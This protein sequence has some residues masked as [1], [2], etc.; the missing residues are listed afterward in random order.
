MSASYIPEDINKFSHL[1]NAVSDINSIPLSDDESS[2]IIYEAREY[3]NTVAENEDTYYHEVFDKEYN[4]AHGKL[5]NE[6]KILKSRLYELHPHSNGSVDVVN[7]YTWTT[8]PQLSDSRHEVPYIQ[9][10]EYRLKY[11]ADIQQLAFNYSRAKDSLTGLRRNDIVNSIVDYT[12]KAIESFSTDSASTTDN[13]LS[14][15]IQSVSSYLN[16]DKVRSGIK[17]VNNTLSAINDDTTSFT[18][19]HLK[20]YDKMYVTNPTGWVFTFPFMLDDVYNTPVNQW[21]QNG[22][23]TAIQGLTNI[24]NDIVGAMTGMHTTFRQLEGNYSQSNEIP[25]V[26]NFS[27][28]GTS[29]TVKFPLINTFN[30]ADYIKNW[31]LVFLLK[32]N[33]RPYKV[34]RNMVLA[35]PI[36]SI[37]IPG[38]RYI[39]Y[40]FIQNITIKYLGTRI[41][42]KVPF[43]YNGI[44]TN[45]DTIVPEAFDIE[46][47]IQSL[48]NETR[49]FMMA[50]LDP[51]SLTY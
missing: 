3:A 1:W 27:T 47:Q 41:N 26:Y 50:T 38:V 10:N 21:T 33:S 9:M 35:P 11:G 46:I 16:S 19:I 48:T 51:D 15:I 5:V 36:Y 29:F 18:N 2:D 14:T 45:I 43:I 23:G 12:K 28:E 25:K 17:Q 44:L 6:Y 40:A 39:P 20:A 7:N 32:Y 13:K 24:S 49:N 22:N 34:D 42:T 8:S 31:Q 30:D 4:K 37:K